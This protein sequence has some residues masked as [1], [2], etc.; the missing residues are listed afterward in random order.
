M[1]LRGAK[2]RSNLL[3]R[4]RATLVI[5]SAAKQPPG[6]RCQEAKPCHC[7]RSEATCKQSTVVIARSEATKQSP[8]P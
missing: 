1:E 5:A 4:Q 7:E 8:Y 6:N 2:R 3:L